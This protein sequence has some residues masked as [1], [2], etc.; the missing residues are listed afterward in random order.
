[1]IAIDERHAVDAQRKAADHHAKAVARIA[2]G[3]LGQAKRQ[4]QASARWRATR[5]S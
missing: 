2:E 4:Q 1:M 5:L 3:K